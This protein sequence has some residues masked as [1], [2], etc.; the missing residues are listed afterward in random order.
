MI[1]IRQ[2]MLSNCY[3]GSGCE[4]R[5][6]VEEVNE[7]AHKVE[8]ELAIY[9]G[10]LQLFADKLWWAGKAQNKELV[11]FYLHEMEEAMEEVHEAGIVHDG[12]NISDLVEPYGLLAIERMEKI[13]LDSASFSNGY[14][15]LVSSCNGCHK[16]SN[17]SFIKIKIPESPV[18]SNQDMSN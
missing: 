2:F 7:R 14:S 18:F 5:V 16:A 9:M 3:N 1:V 15:D 12:V 11:Q 8:I 4:T 10:R 13:D 17:Y 6:E